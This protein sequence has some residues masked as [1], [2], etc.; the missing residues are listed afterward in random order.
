M[1]EALDQATLEAVEAFDPRG[2]HRALSSG[3]AEA[4]GGGA[5]AAVL[6]A[7]ERLGAT[8]AETITYAHSDNVSGD[9]TS[10]VGYGAVRI[11]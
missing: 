7:A 1:A 11:H 10:V 5:I 4:C 3:Q 8:R 9:R 6:I 2:L